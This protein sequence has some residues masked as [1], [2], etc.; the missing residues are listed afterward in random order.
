MGSLSCLLG[1]NDGPAVSSSSNVDV[2]EPFN[3]CKPSLAFIPEFSA[4]FDESAAN[5][6]KLE[7]KDGIGIAWQSANKEELLASP[8]PYIPSSPSPPKPPKKR[9]LQ[10]SLASSPPPNDVID[11]QVLFQLYIQ[12]TEIISDTFMEQ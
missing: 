10:R 1:P 3:F 12:E 9:Y 4:H 8:Q 11:F 7:A 2:T 6:M 5:G